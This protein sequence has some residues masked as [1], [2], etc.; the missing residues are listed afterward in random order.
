MTRNDFQVREVQ[1]ID[2]AAIWQLHNRALADTGAHAGNGDWDR[3]VR[4][5][6]TSYVQ[7]GGNFLVCELD[8][9]V[10]GMGAYIPADERSVEIKRMR[11]DPAYQRTG[12]GK[13]ILY[14]LE[15]HAKRCGFVRSILETTQQQKPA[16]SFYE[17]NGYRR[18]R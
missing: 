3:D 17:R 13:R 12:I 5:P 15:S 10:V 4:D 8:G 7:R 6:L 1:S 18:T 16:Q 14:D 11:V 2:L 9:L